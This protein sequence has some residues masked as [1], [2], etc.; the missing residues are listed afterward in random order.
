VDVTLEDGLRALEEAAALSASIRIELD[1]EYL[2]HIA[3]VE[4]L[5]ANQPGADKTWVWTAEE[6]FRAHY[7]NARRV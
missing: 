2:R 6:S 5:A 7:R 1:E 4:A 3:R